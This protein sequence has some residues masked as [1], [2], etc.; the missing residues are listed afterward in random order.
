MERLMKAQALN[1]NQSSGH[2][3]GRRILE[4]NPSHVMIMSL[5]QKIVENK[6][7]KDIVNVV[8]LLFNTVMLDSGFSLEEPSK[9]AQMIY[10]LIGLGLRGEEEDVPVPEVQSTD[11][12]T[13]TSM[14]DLD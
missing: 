6:K 12:K 11:E 14:E 8:E 13:T 3:S 7:E 5:K 10:R 1:S 2:M 9:Y 4:I